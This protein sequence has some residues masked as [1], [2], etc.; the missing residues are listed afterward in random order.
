MEVKVVS[1][2]L[3]KNS[4]SLNLTKDSIHPTI[5]GHGILAQAVFEY[6]S[7]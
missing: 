1:M 4:N 3:M 7:K 2:K 6:L 5:Y